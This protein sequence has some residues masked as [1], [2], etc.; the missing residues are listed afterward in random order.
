MKTLAAALTGQEK[1]AV[2]AEIDSMTSQYIVKI[3]QLQTWQ[4]LIFSQ[5]KTQTTAQITDMTTNVIGQMRRL[6]DQAVALSIW[7]DML[8]LMNRQTE[9]GLGAVEKRFGKM[10]DTVL[11]NMPSAPATMIPNA[12]GG[13]LG[14]GGAS[15]SIVNHVYGP[16]VTIEG[17]ADRATAELAATQVMEKLKTIIVEPSSMGV[18]PTMKR[19]RKAALF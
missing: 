18:G 10:S 19:I 9:E 2:L 1:D 8:E 16:L 12:L 11:G 17:S 4:D 3:N 14:R 6:S 7:P 5:I 13:S 15:T